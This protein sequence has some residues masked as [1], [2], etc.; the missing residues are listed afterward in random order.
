MGLDSDD[1]RPEGIALRD[2]YAAIRSWYQ[3]NVDRFQGD[4][5]RGEHA[6]AVRA[7]VASMP[8]PKNASRDD[9]LGAFRRVLMGDLEWAYHE[10]DGKYKMAA[11]AQ[12]AVDAAGVNPFL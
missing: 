12:A 11:Y 8:Q 2:A 4:P 1:P 10:S 9:M 5:Q 6:K 3:T 7:Y